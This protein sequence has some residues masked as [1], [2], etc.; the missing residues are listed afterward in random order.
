MREYKKQV[1]LTSKTLTC[2]ASTDRVG[3]RETTATEAV[4]GNEDT[5]Q[6]RWEEVTWKLA[7]MP[8]VTGDTWNFCQGEC[9]LRL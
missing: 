4:Y 1:S 8:R 6:V 2:K 7:V 9:K 3:D 5:D